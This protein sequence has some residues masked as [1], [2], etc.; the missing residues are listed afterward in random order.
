MKIKKHRNFKIII[1]VRLNSTRLPKKILKKIYNNQSMLEF[2]LNRLTKKFKTED[3]IIALAKNKMNFPIVKILNKY[4]VKYFEGSENNVLNRYY[5]CAQKFNADNIVRIT[6][7][8]PLIDTD[9]ILKMI[10][11]FKENSYEYLA[12]T[13]PEKNK[14]FPD[15]SDIEIFK[16]SSMKKMMKLNLTKYEKE[17]V[18]NRFWLSKI[19]KSKLYKTKVDLSQYRYSVDYQSDIVSIK[20]II[21]FLNKKKLKF[22]A[23]NIAKIINNNS[24]IKKAMYKN[25]IKHKK[26]RQKIFEL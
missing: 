4:K 18:T 6:S 8:C 7:D 11:Y 22:T 1:Q 17:H 13:L 16:F 26:R 19:F 21:Y 2:L 3:I 24:F 15:G 10:K 23:I 5:K 20:K 25:I 12:N 14:T 9:L